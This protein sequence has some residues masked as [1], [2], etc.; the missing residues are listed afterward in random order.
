[1]ATNQFVKTISKDPYTDKFSGD[2]ETL[3]HI[4]GLLEAWGEIDRNGADEAVRQLNYNQIFRIKE[5]VSLLSPDFIV[6]IF[7]NG[8][9]SDKKMLNSIHNNL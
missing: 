8:L 7:I 4:R 9:E 3:G 2:F 1:M 6:H 5:L